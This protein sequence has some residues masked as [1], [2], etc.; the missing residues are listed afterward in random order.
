MY[1][2]F[3]K[4]IMFALRF[5]HLSQIL[6]K[7]KRELKIREKEKSAGGPGVNPQI[8]YRKIENY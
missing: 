6:L 5:A 8:N 3:T 2:L 7:I 4:I 1:F